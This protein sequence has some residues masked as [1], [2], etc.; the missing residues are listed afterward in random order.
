M[1]MPWSFSVEKKEEE[2]L[3][4]FPSIVVVDFKPC[5]LGVSGGK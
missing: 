4:Q 3:L 1:M 5:S 2:G